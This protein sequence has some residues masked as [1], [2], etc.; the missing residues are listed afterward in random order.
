[1]A[2]FLVASILGMPKFGSVRF[3]EDFAEL[4]TGPSVQVHDGP[5]LVQEG[6]ELRT[7]LFTYQNLCNVVSA[8]DNM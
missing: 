4:R 8:H 5:V 7:E 6:F 3:F 1:V 2:K